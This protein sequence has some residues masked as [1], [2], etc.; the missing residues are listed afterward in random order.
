[1]ERFWTGIVLAAVLGAA[2]CTSPTGTSPRD[3]GT[4]PIDDAGPPLSPLSVGLLVASR[5]SDQVLRYDGAGTPQGVFASSSDLVRPVGITFGP[6]GNLYVA[7]GD[8]NHVLRFNGSTGAAMGVFTDGGTIKSPR[9]INFGPD[10]AFYVADGVLNQVIRF[11]GTTGAFDRILIENR[12]LDGP[13]SFTFGPDGQVYVV[14]VLTNEV[15][16]FDGTTGAL[17]G[18]FATQGL[19][20]PHDVSFGPDGNLYVSN[21]GSTRVQRFRGDTGEFLDTFVEDSGL[22]NPLGMA[23]GPDGNLFLAN[24]GVNEIR[25]YDGRSGAR[26]PT[27]VTGGAGGLSAPAF[28]LFLA[29]PAPS[30]QAVT[31]VARTW[32]SVVASGAQPGARLLLVSGSDGGTST[33]TECPELVLP[34]GVAMVEEMRIADESGATVISV[35]GTAGSQHTFLAVDA[36]RCQASGP[37]TVT[38]P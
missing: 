15:L 20:Q 10:G 25:R 26:L 14:S 16:R 12:A 17:I 35:T 31:D 33:L 32:V 29:P 8:T 34:L 11:D 36:A 4:L 27:F 21:S 5:G 13:T 22:V 30:L 23:W 38:V 3:A 6:D 7:A 18:S 1:M 19:T 28:L 24:Q 2:A 9:N 37:T